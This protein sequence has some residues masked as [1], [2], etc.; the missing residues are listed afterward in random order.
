MKVMKVVKYSALGGITFGIA[1]LLYQNKKKEEQL[2]ID[3]M[4]EIMD[5]EEMERRKQEMN[6]V[7]VHMIISQFIDMIFKNK[8]IT[9][10]EAILN[11][12]KA[13]KGMTLEKF[14]ESKSRNRQSYIKI[15]KPHFKE[16]KNIIFE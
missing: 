1:Y 7:A 10:E 5:M 9:L 15:Y 14:A 8:N 16:A 12:E 13:K 3:E 4:N 2:E 11:F 6:D